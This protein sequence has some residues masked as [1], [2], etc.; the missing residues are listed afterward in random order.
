MSDIDDLKAALPTVA[1]MAAD[2]S[3]TLDSDKLRT[4]LA[5]YPVTHIPA[6]TSIISSVLQIDPV[7]PDLGGVRLAYT[8]GSDGGFFAYDADDSTTA[9][10]PIYCLV[11]IGGKRYKRSGQPKIASVKS[12]TTTTV[13]A[14]PDLGDAYLY[15]SGGWGAEGGSANQI[16]VYSSLGGGS[17]QWVDAAFGPPLYVEDEDSYV[18]WDGSAWADGPNARSGA[19]DSV[20]LSEIQG[21]AASLTIRVENQTT[22]A[23]PGSRKTGATPA[24]PLGGTAVNIND[25]SDATTSVTSALGDLTGASVAS[26]IIAKLSL[27]AATDLIAIEARGVLG[28]AASS[29]SAMGLYYSTDNGATWTQAGSG[30][31]LS[32]TA[33]NVVRTGSFAGV[34]DVALVTEAKNW[35]TDTNTLAQLNAY[36]GTVTASVG[37]AWIVAA[38]GFGVLSGWDGSVARCEISNTLTRYVPA[39]GDE[40][41]DKAS[42]GR[43]RWVAALSAWVTS[44]GVVAKKY[45]KTDG[46]GSNT[47]RD[48]GS[49]SGYDYSDTSWFAGSWTLYLGRTDDATIT[50]SA[51]SPDNILEFHYEARCQGWQ[52]GANYGT[53]AVAGDRPAAIGVWRD[54]ETAPIAWTRANDAIDGA[55]TF[56]DPRLLAVTFALAAGDTN[57][58]IYTVRIISGFK[59]DA[60]GDLSRFPSSISK[61]LFSLTEFG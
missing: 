4:W 50:H 30:F 56:E 16:G 8:Y 47:L 48:S 11:L 25:N 15:I 38:G 12:R 44:Q 28:S 19:A 5:K 52:D 57:E 3:K 17:W 34:T 14:S 37:D 2:P 61:R 29:A 51:Q 18:H 32:T 49:V 43:F 1:A 10:D 55:G 40:V 42:T 45:V 58:H 9:Q 22:Y 24:V 36:D 26:R 60:A 35:S 31:T 20:K 54:D 13:P 6:S 33:Q 7:D 21:C 46:T 59:N 39:D 53:G 41:Y 23:P 27:A